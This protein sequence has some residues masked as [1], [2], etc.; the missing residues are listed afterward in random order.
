MR[1]LD[2]YAGKGGELRR[3]KI[4]RRGHRYVTLDLDPRFGCTV[5]ADVFKLS[6][7]ELTRR[8]GRFDFVWASPPCEAFSVASMSHHWGGG[9]RAYVPKTEHAR[10][11][12]RLIQRTI[13]LTRQ[14]NPRLGWLMENPRG[15]LRKLPL[16]A[17]LPRVTVSYCRYGDTRMKPTDL[18]GDVP[19]W[20]PRAMCHN[21]HPDHDYAPRGTRT[22]GTQGQKNAADRAVVPWP[23]W[24]EILVALEKSER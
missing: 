7:A 17:K 21:G 16:T 5:T 12:L 22:G 4:E 14:L 3:E 9:F 19:G 13:R 1:I 15:V 23:L 10:L 2:L 6:A 20:Q 24:R 11:S 8:F 18:W